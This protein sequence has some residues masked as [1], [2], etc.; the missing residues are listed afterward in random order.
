MP[1]KRDCRPHRRALDAGTPEDIHELRST[2]IDE[3]KC[4]QRYAVFKHHYGTLLRLKQYFP[5][6][7]IDGA[8]QSMAVY[9]WNTMIVATSQSLAGLCRRRHLLFC[10][11]SAGKTAGSLRMLRL[12]ACAGWSGRRVVHDAALIFIHCTVPPLAMGTTEECRRQIHRELRYQSSMD[13][14]AATYAAIR[15][16]TA[17]RLLAEAD[18]ALLYDLVIAGCLDGEWFRRR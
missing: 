15:W 7:L 16:S 8:L 2:D 14:D 11:P 6:S 17:L 5:F 3:A 10:Q 12:S 4:R 13:L 1:N 18:H 9:L